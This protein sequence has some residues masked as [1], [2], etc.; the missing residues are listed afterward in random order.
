MNQVDPLGFGPWAVPHRRPLFFFFFFFFFTAIARYQLWT[1][2]STHSATRPCA[3]PITPPVAITHSK[4]YL[5]SKITTLVLVNHLVHEFLVD[6]TYCR[7]VPA[8]VEDDF[9]SITSTLRVIK[10]LQMG[11]NFIR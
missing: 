10:C 4:T 8:C 6:V 2:M 5:T 11:H 9:G 7:I 1:P 3:Q